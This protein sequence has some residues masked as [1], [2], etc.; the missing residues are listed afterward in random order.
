MKLHQSGRLPDWERSEAAVDNLWQH[1]ARKSHGVV[2]PGN[3]LSL[4]GLVL[5]CGGAAAIAG[6][7][8]GTGI[9]GIALGR[10]CDLADGIVADMTGTKSPLGEAVDAACDKLALLAVIIGIGVSGVMW[11][12]LLGLI[13]LQNLANSALAFVAKQKSITLHPSRLGKLATAWQW[14]GLIGLSMAFFFPP[15]LWVA[16]AAS[17]VGL[18]AGYKATWCYAAAFK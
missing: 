8:Y 6:G 14:V 7:F 16:A 11:W 3:V 10:T 5:V 9:V 17:I 18:V 1:I 13:A 15:I 12:P 2:T 4:A